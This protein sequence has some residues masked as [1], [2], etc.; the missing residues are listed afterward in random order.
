MRLIREKSELRRWRAVCRGSGES[1]ALVP[2]MG[3]LHDGHLRLIDRA[4]D[5]ADRV[6]VSIFV[7]PLQFG[8]EEDFERYPRD[9]DADLQLADERGVDVVFAPAGS[10]MYPPDGVWTAVVP[11]RGADRLCGRSRPGHFRGV[12][13]VVAKL[14]G[15]V[16]PEV[17]VFGRK[18]LQQG[19]LI[20][21][22]VRDLD[23]P[24]SVDVA[25][26]VREEDG[27]ALSSRNRYLS[28]AERERALALVGALEACRDAFR[29]GEREAGG[30]V[31]VLRQRLQEADGVAVEYAEIV[32][33]GRLEPVDPVPAGAVAAVA[34]LV[35]ETRLIDNMILE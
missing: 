1:V 23:L 4:R 7:N 30:L 16:Q 35:G 21:R 14:F 10:E 3:S 11:E 6:V 18:D 9:L 32:D 27:L 2:T 28:A 17:A 13:T 5:L 8:P 19:V 34:A 29:A 24:V 15:V 12:L 33:P 22:M 20:Q 25:P 26:I 31:S